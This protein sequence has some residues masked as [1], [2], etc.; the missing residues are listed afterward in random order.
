MK[1]DKIINTLGGMEAFIIDL[2]IKIVISNI[3]KIP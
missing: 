3:A 1:E 2:C